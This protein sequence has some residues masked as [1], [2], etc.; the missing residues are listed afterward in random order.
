M[1]IKAIKND[2]DLQQA[3]IQLQPIFQAPEG[4]IEAENREIL[5]TL[6]EN[7]ENEHYLI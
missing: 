6:I 3:F 5:V 4:T 7:Y 1:N 2:Q